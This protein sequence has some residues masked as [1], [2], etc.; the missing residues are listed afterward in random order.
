MHCLRK[1]QKQKAKTKK[2]ATELPCFKTLKIRHGWCSFYIRNQAQPCRLSLGQS[3][4]DSLVHRGSSNSSFSTSLA[5]ASKPVWELGSATG[6]SGKFLRTDSVFPL[7]LVFI[8][9]CQH[10]QPFFRI[11]YCLGVACM[12]TVEQVTQFRN[13]F[14]RLWSWNSLSVQ[15]T[16]G[17]Y[18]LKKATE[19]TSHR[20]KTQLSSPWRN[21][22]SLNQKLPQ[23]WT[24]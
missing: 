21:T 11:K 5:I 24:S 9:R 18:P 20:Q 17:W 22:L 10:W 8:C 7:F 14:I 6:R 16:M 12:L 23:P 19:N 13:S 3:Y 4:W 1:K 15:T 2:N